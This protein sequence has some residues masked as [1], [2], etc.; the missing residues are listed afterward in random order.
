MPAANQTKSARTETA[1]VDSPKVLL[2]DLETSPN[3]GYTWG[4]RETDVIKVLHPRQI[5][6]IAWKWL[7][8]DDVKVLSLPH[9]PNYKR[10]KRDNKALMLEIHKLFGK[11]D[12]VVGHN[13]KRF[14]DRRSNTDFIKHGLKPPPPHAQVDT[15]EFARF[16]FDFNSNK[17]DDLGDFLGLGR[18]VKHPGFEMWEKCLEGDPEAWALMEKYNKGDVVLLE[19]VYLKLRPWMKNHPALTPRD[20]AFFAC[21]YCRSP[22]VKSEGHRYTKLGKA[23][24]YSCLEPNCGKWSTG[25]IVNRELRLS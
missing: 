23:P 21:P 13:V 25:R 9:F 8:E 12:I 19:K 20:R 10:D 17:L 3:I 24:R 2:Y 11:A 16:K 4:T 1:E 5:I 6:S 15:L 18:K 22:R 14:D 7:G